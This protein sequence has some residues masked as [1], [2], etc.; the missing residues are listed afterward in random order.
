[1]D[2]LQ[3]IIVNLVS[4]LIVLVIVRLL[5]SYF[6]EKGKNLAT[7]EDISEITKEIEQVKGL[8]KKRND[9]SV[10]ERGFYNDMIQLMEGFLKEIKRYEL[11]TGKG[12]NSLTREEM[13]ANSE[14]RGKFLSFLD[15]TNAFF[16]KAFV[17]LDEESYERLRDAIDRE[18]DVAHMRMN[19][20]NAMRKSIHANTALRAE[21]DSKDFKYF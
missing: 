15:S 11:Q 7:K 9:L 13:M 14:L 2:Y 12:E 5:P 20:L 16:S 6:S 1:M 17:F 4:I 3:E 21:V 10:A 18:N 8:Y 19:L